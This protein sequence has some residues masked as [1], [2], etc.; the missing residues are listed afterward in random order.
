MSSAPLETFLARLYT[1]PVALQR[2]IADPQGEAA[3]AGLSAAESQ[4]MAE[5][6]QVGL[7]MA[8][9]SFG[10]KR[11]QHRKSR[12]PLYRRIWKGLLHR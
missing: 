12:A 3:R 4:A 1:D 11:E 5:S 7:Q 8:A 10:S 2:F 9:V 6:D